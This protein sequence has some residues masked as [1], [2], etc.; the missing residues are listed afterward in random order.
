[1]SISI[2]FFVQA[3]DEPDPSNTNAAR[4]LDAIYLKLIED[5]LSGK[6]DINKLVSLEEANRNGYKVKTVKLYNPKVLYLLILKLFG[7]A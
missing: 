4:T 2:W 5:K 3:Q 1:M 6:I 7:K